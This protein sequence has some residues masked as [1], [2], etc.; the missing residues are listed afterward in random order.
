MIATLSSK[1][2]VTLPKPF[3]DRLDLHAGDKLDF[4]VKENGTLE[5]I[6]LKQPA[7]KLRGMLPKPAKPVSI[8]EMNAAIAQGASGQ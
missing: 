5:V 8:E 4:I 3:R 7:S 6:P 2:Q 1:G